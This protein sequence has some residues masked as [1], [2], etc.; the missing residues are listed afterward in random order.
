MSLPSWDFLKFSHCFFSPCYIRNQHALNFHQEPDLPTT[1]SSGVPAAPTALAAAY[2][3]HLLT[4]AAVLTSHPSYTS[5]TLRAL[6]GVFYLISKWPNHHCLPSNS[7]D[8]QRRQWHSLQ[9]SCLEN[10][11]GGGAWRAAAHGVAKSR[12]QLSDFTFTFMHW[13]RNW[14]PTPVLAWRIPGMAEPGGL[15]STGSHRVRHDW[16]DLAA[17]AACCSPQWLYQFAFPTTSVRSFPFL[18][19]LSSIYCL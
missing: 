13:R 9:C 12:T 2:S 7:D 4:S 5:I 15:P 10:P 8:R 19:T 11:T 16:S 14:Q 3:N 17:V 18:H 6:T 1:C